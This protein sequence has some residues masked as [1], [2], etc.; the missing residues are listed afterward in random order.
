M[1]KNIFFECKGPYLLC[2]LFE[3]LKEEVT[4][5]VV[6]LWWLCGDEC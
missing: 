2:D 5:M 6:G 4:P 3:N 1:V